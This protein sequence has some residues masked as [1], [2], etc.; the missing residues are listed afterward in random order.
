MVY[1]L[2]SRPDAPSG[3]EGDRFRVQW[4]PDDS[5]LAVREGDA[6]LIELP[7][8]ELLARGREHGEHTLP[9]DSMR[10]EAENDSVRARLQLTW[11]SGS[12]AETE[13]SVGLQGRVLLDLR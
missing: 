11:I 2:S 12:R 9:P 5:S 10:V 7:L 13:E 8:E 6:L 1:H 3:V 4:N